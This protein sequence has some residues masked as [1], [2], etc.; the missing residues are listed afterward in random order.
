MDDCLRIY[1]YGDNAVIIEGWMER[2]IDVTYAPG[3]H[4]RTEPI[5]IEIGDDVK[6]GIAVT[7]QYY[8]ATRS[9]AVWSVAFEPLGDDGLPCPWPV[10]FDP[11]K[12]REETF[13]L[14]VYCRAGTPVRAWRG[15]A[16]YVL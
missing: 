9:G 6:G 3:T 2:Q 4:V 7:L 13:G 15:E 5:R 11:C 10:S 14:V 16:G 8:A 12:D 1:G